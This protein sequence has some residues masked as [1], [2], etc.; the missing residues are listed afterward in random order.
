[1]ILPAANINTQS[2]S[3]NILRIRTRF[4]SYLTIVCDSGNSYMACLVMSLVTCLYTCSSEF[5]IALSL[6]VAGGGVRLVLDD[7]MM[8]LVL[9]M[10]LNLLQLL[11]R[12]AATIGAP[13][14]KR[15]AFALP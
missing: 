9:I 2:P 3:T 13:G 6:I 11:R 15:Y 14:S 5:L 12:R 7:L 10:L 8:V 4:E 1:M